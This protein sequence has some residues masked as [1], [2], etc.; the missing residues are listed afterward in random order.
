MSVE[1]HHQ[2]YILGV[3]VKGRVE[4]TKCILLFGCFKEKEDY[5][6]TAEPHTYLLLCSQSRERE[7]EGKE[8]KKEPRNGEKWSA[9]CAVS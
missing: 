8:E 4:K 2:A 5:D 9:Q 3:D 1:F 7:S 6:S